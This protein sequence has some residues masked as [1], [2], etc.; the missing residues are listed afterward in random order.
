MVKK[1]FRP[2]LKLV[3]L[4]S[5]SGTNLQA[6]IDRIKDGRLH[7]EIVAVIS[8][9]PDA[10]GLERARKHNITSIV[11]DYKKYGK[12]ELPVIPW[13]KLPANFDQLVESQRLFPDIRG[14]KLREK[15]ARMVLAE[16]ELMT[17]IDKFKPDYICLAGFMKL[18]SP[19]FIRHYQKIV[20]DHPGTCSTSPS[21]WKII[22]IHPALLP[23]FPG[24]N[25]Y[26]DTFDY[27][28]RFGGIT[29]HFVDEGE[30]TGPVIGQ[31][32]Y[33]IWPEDTLEDIRERGLTLEY[34]LYSQC[35]NWIAYGYLQVNSNDGERITFRITDPD[36]KDFIKRLLELSMSYEDRRG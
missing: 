23:A 20:S 8:D 2:K 12:K 19:Y 22:N 35:I 33:P 9:N 32:I 28:C 30:D 3:V 14:Q 10:Y 7:A 5:G 24:V 15:L 1:N 16:K 17:V 26:G 4:L 21:D 29:V 31:A 18:L 6:M 27:G 34:E 25:G 13:D 36:Y 11:I